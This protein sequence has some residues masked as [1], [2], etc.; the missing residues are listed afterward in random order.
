MD[1][2]K[3]SVLL[4]LGL[5]IFLLIK[6]CACSRKNKENRENRE[7]MHYLNQYEVHDHY[8]NNRGIWPAGDTP[9]TAKY[10]LNNATNLLVN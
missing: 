3:L 2:L 8:K 5:Y 9:L 10:K 7:N 1:I 4:L 6:S